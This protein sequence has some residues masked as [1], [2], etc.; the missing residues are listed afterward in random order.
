MDNR[1]TG[2]PPGIVR[3]LLLKLE[4]LDS[5]PTGYLSESFVLPEYLFSNLKEQ[6]HCIPMAHTAERLKWANYCE[7]T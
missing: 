6:H 5:L 2:K 4:N 3:A 1:N 7:K